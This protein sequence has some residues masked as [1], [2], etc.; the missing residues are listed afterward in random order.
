MDYADFYDATKDAFT[1]AL[2]ETKAQSAM[3]QITPFQA[4]DDDDI[5]IE[6]VGISHQD[7]E[8]SFIAIKERD[9]EIYP[10]MVAGAYRP[11]LPRPRPLRD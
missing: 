3:I 10:V 8:L 6:V 5:P 4:L 2:A 11:A 1:A 7:E 9:G